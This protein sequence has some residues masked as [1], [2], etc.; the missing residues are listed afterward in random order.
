MNDIDLKFL[1]KKRDACIEALSY[2]SPGGASLEKD[3]LAAFN[4][5]VNM[6]QFIIENIEN[7]KTI[8]DNPYFYKWIRETISFHRASNSEGLPV[9][10]KLKDFIESRSSVQ[11]NLV[12]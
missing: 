11:S 1:I 3:L 7:P 6:L 10:L 5:E 9:F 12:K 8:E 2:V 4:S